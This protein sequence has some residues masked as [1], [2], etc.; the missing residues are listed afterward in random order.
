MPLTIML[1][2]TGVTSPPAIELPM[3]KSQPT[4]STLA[5]RV[6]AMDV[7]G[8]EAVKAGVVEVGGEG[9]KVGV[10][11]VKDLERKKDRERMNKLLRY[12]SVTCRALP[13]KSAAI[14]QHNQ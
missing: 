3:P 1:R 6:V 4:S 13:G 14:V 12:W 9:I 11:M 5:A 2:A 7:A 10:P 8:V